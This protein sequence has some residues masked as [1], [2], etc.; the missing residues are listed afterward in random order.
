MLMG[1]LYVRLTALLSGLPVNET[2]I[3]R[4]RR[5][6]GCLDPLSSFCYAM[7]SLD[8]GMDGSSHLGGVYALADVLLDYEI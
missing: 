8:G 4:P 7:A 6:R 2:F 3:E 1:A 5:S